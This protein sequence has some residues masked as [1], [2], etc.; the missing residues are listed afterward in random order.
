MCKILYSQSKKP[1]AEMIVNSFIEKPIVPTLNGRIVGGDT[2]SIENFP[3]Q[4]QLRLEGRHQ[5]GAVIIG[6]RW[7]LTAAHCIVGF[8]G[9]FT[10]RSGSSRINSGGS[11]HQISRISIH[12]SYNTITYDFDIAAVEIA[13]HFPL[14]AF[15]VQIIR[16]PVLNLHPSEGSLAVVSGWGLTSENGTFSERLQAVGVPIKSQIRCREIYGNLF[17][18]RMICAGFPQGGRDAC[19]G[20]SGGPLV[21]DNV[22]FGIVSWGT[23]CAR[24]NLPGVYANIANLRNWIST[25]TGI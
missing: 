13:E 25:T 21:F 11:I 14:G 22:L 7:A 15:G 12:T 18:D 19:N 9:R 23:G 16:L 5:C 17:T 10:I 1:R 3:Y 2:V 20:D 6:I 24:P 8:D 4:L